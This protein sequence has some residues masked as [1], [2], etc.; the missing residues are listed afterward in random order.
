M[1][2]LKN[3]VIV[4][5]YAVISLAVGLLLASFS[6]VSATA[7]IIGGFVVFLAV[8][9][10]HALYERRIEKADYESELFELHQ[11]QEEAIRELRTLNERME[12][13]REYAADAAEQRSDKL[14]AEIRVLKSLLQQVA[15]RTKTRQVKAASLRTI[16]A[17]ELDD[18]KILSIMRS[19]LEDNRVD[20]YLQPVVSLPQRRMR[21]Y[22]AFS[23]VRDE[24]DDIIFPKQ[25]IHVA[26]E[27]GLIGSLDNLLLFRC[28]QVIRQLRDRRADVR[29]FCNIS[30]HSLRDMDF[31]PQFLDFM[32]SNR[33]LA[34]RLVFEFPKHD[35]EGLDEDLSQGL[36]ALGALGFQ[37]SLDHV[38]DL[39]F[40]LRDLSRKNF[41][42]IKVPA[43][44]L[45]D[46]AGDI[47]SA[48][49]KEALARF[50]IDLICEQVE[51]ERT[52]TNILDYN[53]DYGQGYL[54][55]EPRPSRTEAPEETAEA[56]PQTE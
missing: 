45:L 50:D 5:S 15:S 11:D 24:D 18:G 42:F 17:N 10:L 54:F 56:A 2:T 28:I 1:E 9:Q 30:A 34:E 46:E 49:L 44:V 41:R 29:F 6:D 13:L 39:D 55:G 31:F 21:H 52:L 51:D 43:G 33:G 36:E 19:A 37:F 12:E 35:I 38:D 48:D 26:E 4:V 53:V 14:V 20:L 25:F 47:H 40:D 22:E 32:R 23:R 27:S 3:I 8:A 7:A 16:N